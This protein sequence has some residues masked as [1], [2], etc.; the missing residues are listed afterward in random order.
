LTNSIL[1][2]GLEEPLILTADH[3]I[4][5]GHRRFVVC[6]ALGMKLIPC[7]VKHDIRRIGNPDF[8]KDLAAYNPQRVKSAGALLREAILRDSKTLE[9]TQA[10]IRRVTATNKPTSKPRY[11]TVV[12]EKFVKEVSSRKMEFL[13]AVQR[14]VERLEPYWPLTIRQ[15]HYQ[16]L[17]APPLKL[18][19]KRSRLGL[20]HYR[21]RNDYSS[22]S[23]L[24]DLCTQARYS[25]A[26]PWE[27]VDD[28]T[29]TQGRH[30]GF[31]SVAD[32]IE[33]E[34]ERFLLGY[35]RDKQQ[36]QPLHIEVLFE[37]NTLTNIVVPVCKDYYTQWTSG[38]GFAG[39]SIWRKMA[40]RFEES[41]KERMVLL[42][43][44]DF[45]PEGFALADDALRS[46]RDL[47]NVPVDCHRVGVTDKQIKELRLQQDFNPAKKDSPNFKAFV[48]RTGS[49]R[50]WECEA[51]DPEY[52][53]NQLR[54]AIEANMNMGIFKMA[55]ALEIEDSKEIHRLR[56]DIA[57][58][59]KD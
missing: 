28:I 14:V 16:L 27:S 29:R 54:R 30:A 58:G 43:V 50:T 18:T 37:K 19:P 12:G 2:R 59:F 45:D 51:L 24:S 21:Y 46:L 41:C 26:I 22:Y 49:D 9:D 20:E 47:W 15:L 57:R 42:I 10:A 3:Y 53:R 34:M 7:R 23:A 5:S 11:E 6:E 31:N 39:P 32:F 40:E 56:T 17:N 36:D 33:Y 38:R 44:S 35:H 55:Q 4:M 48:E 52:L 13:A 25:G 8:I 1:E